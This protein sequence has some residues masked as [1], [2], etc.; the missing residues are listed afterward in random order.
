MLWTVKRAPYPSRAFN[1]TALMT[2]AR[3]ITIMR[4]VTAATRI[5]RRWLVVMRRKKNK[6]ER[7]GH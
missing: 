3:V 4:R 1:A 2:K 5:H 6:N 7:V